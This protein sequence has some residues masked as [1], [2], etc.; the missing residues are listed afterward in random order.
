MKNKLA[1]KVLS[2]VTSFALVFS[3]SGA[4]PNKILEKDN[5]IQASAA[6]TDNI[7]LSGYC[8]HDIYYLMKNE[9]VKDDKYG[10]LEGN[11]NYSDE[12]FSNAKVKLINKKTDSVINTYT[13]ENGYYKFENVSVSNLANYSIE[14]EYNGLDYT[15]SPSSVNFT[16]SSF[17]CT[18]KADEDINRRNVIN[19]MGLN[20]TSGKLADDNYTI[21]ASISGEFI[22]NYYKQLSN[23][24]KTNVKDLEFMNIG[25]Y[26]RNMTDISLLND[27]YA[28][29]LIDDGNK[30][31]FRYN[32]NGK[33]NEFPFNIQFDGKYT[34]PLNACEISNTVSDDNLSEASVFYKIELVN[35]TGEVFAE[36]NSINVFYTN[37][38]E[39]KGVYSASYTYYDNTKLV[40]DVNI[41]KPLN[42]SCSD[43]NNSHGNQELNAY[44]CKNIV[45]DEPIK[46]GARLSSMTSIKYVFLEFK[47]KDSLDKIVNKELG[48]KTYSEIG[49]YS[50]YSDNNFTVPY[51]GYDYNSTP[52]N[53][54]DGINAEDDDD[55][56][57]GFKVLLRTELH[58]NGEPD[59][60]KYSPII[61]KEPTC[62]ETGIRKYKCKCGDSYTEEI[63]KL[64]HD[65]TTKVVDPTYTERGYTLHSCTRCDYSYKDNYTD[66]LPKP[67]EKKHFEWDK[68]NWNFINSNTYF[69]YNTYRDQI[70]KSYLNTL[71]NNLS[72][73]EYESIFNGTIFENA[74]L[75]D[76][77][78]GSCYGMSSTTLLAKQ[79][80]LPYSEY[81]KNAKT[82][83]DLDKP[84]SNSAV[85]SLITYY[86]MLQ[87]KDVIQ[88]Q[89]RSVPKRSEETNIKNIIS[90][91]DK[92][93]TVLIGFKKDGWGGHAILAY[94]YE[95]GSFKKNG[96]NYQGRIKTCD[97][98]C[99]MTDNE[100]YYIYF[101]TNTYSWAIPAYNSSGV[102]STKGAKFNYI[103]ANI[104]EINEGGYLSGTSSNNI[105]NYVARIDAA[106]I[107]ESRGVTKV[108]EKNGSFVNMNT[109]P[110]DIEEDISYVL[111]GESDGIVGYNLYDGDASYKVTQSDPVELKL[112]ID[113]E[114]CCFSGGSAAGKAVTFGR[115]GIVRVEGESSDYSLSMTFDDDHPTDWFT[116]KVEGS[117][118]WAELTKS[119]DGYI[120]SSDDLRE[121]TVMANNKDI[122]AS[123][124]FSTSFDK[125]LIY[126]I[127]PNTIGI[128]IDDDG[129]GVFETSI[130][131]GETLT[132][133]LG[134]VNADGKIN[135]TDI[136]KVAAHI[137]GRK[138]LDDAAQ[139]CADVNHDGKIN[140][141]DITKI[142]A[143][144]K[145]KKL[146]F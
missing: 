124:E 51:L 13:D 25:L 12:G 8:W 97:P 20:I 70:S 113:Y 73:S 26:S 93:D 22:S 106:A 33:D 85:S 86:Q 135:V 80:L 49:S 101:N 46:L 94:D 84:I 102:T 7:T 62:T 123:G 63:P 30:Y 60:H 129:D 146:L 71:K 37:N 79:G 107:S 28:V 38:L 47:I 95:Y 138:L 66:V 121:F 87:V 10:F 98:N 31:R 108:A 120:L 3:T 40:K 43:I 132:S 48:I 117:G 34:F 127:S 105:D 2:A 119:D 145:G 104:N 6:S 59:N 65:L 41:D 131:S 56:A 82:L 45:F 114:D 23:N 88:Q 91:L 42:Y 133:A 69:G 81:N 103:G 78:G 137:K 110:G 16:S 116:I 1:L 99:S 67:Y 111:C 5:A 4:L 75:D 61:K 141:T 11:S 100:D 118:E 24:G 115:N 58:D 128:K 50:V 15:T 144:I 77:W 32:Q 72:P 29:D 112:S 92:N 18:S 39:L 53:F 17:Y 142:A 68:D 122:K 54:I 21:S 76:K 126:E 90:E 44:V 19:R 36:F 109:A 140:V 35:H 130:E 64:G 14:F 136:T 125:V 89:Y 143:H 83:H 74:W 96:I 57:G 55:G 52:N 9:S 134:D 27:I 139:K